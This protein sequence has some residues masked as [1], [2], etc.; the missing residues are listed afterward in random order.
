[1]FDCLGRDTSRGASLG[2]DDPGLVHGQADEIETAANGALRLIGHRA[3]ID[4][5]VL[6]FLIALHLTSPSICRLIAA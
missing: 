2:V 1:M 5:L 4:Q 3:Q 6:R